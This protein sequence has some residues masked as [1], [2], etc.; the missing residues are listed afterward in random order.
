VRR[1]VALLLAALSGFIALSYEIIWIRVYSMVS[2]GKASAFGALLGAYLAGLALG[3]LVARRFCRP[4]GHRE[5]RALAWFILF[6]NLFGFLLVPATA[7]LVRQL[8]YS[9]TLPLIALGAGLLGTTVPLIAHFGVEPDEHAGAGVSYLYGA[10]IIG[11]TAGSLLTG[12]VLLEFPL[13]FVCV[14]LALSGVLVF[15]ALARRA[16][17]AIAAALLVVVA[18]P[19]LFDS[20]YEKLQFKDDY[21]PGMRFELVEEGR[22]GVVTV[23]AEGEV[24]GGGVYD[25]KY[26]VDPR[27]DIN[28]IF[29][30]YAP[31]AFRPPPRR[32]LVVG[33]GSG[34]WAQ[35]L[36]NHPA[37]E[38]LT[39]VEISSEY[40][41]VVRHSPV[42]R[43]LLDNPKVTIV[44]DD[45]RRWLNRHDAR[46]DWI[47]QNTTY[48][49]R[50]HATNLLSREYL[51]LSRRHLEPGGLLLYNTT[52][53]LDAQKT[54]AAV[55][56]HCWLIDNAMLVSD[57]P[58]I[59]DRDRFRT[60]LRGYTIDGKPVFGPG[61]D[62]ALDA[63]VDDAR[64]HDR[65][66]ILARTR[67][68]RVITDDNMASEWAYLR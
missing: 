10:N 37:L 68:A 14:G 67:D 49:F 25:G 24:F 32:A 63:I 40:L 13:R 65:D 48:H 34:S 59:R 43:S 38:S 19:F 60:V 36:A 57:E 33:L 9:W 30:V 28:G 26:N 17:I 55:F 53:S 3:A 45:G 51:E 46:F 61:D 64:W 15:Y 21:E 54:G 1:R 22:S 5:L 41:A 6:A 18:T 2:W 39:V 11:S 7:E 66:W 58:L 42:V 50:A 4:E 12:F 56:P 8:P 23:T 35:V 52:R 29:R 44:I 20:L 47:V 16:R 27:H 62:A 31:F